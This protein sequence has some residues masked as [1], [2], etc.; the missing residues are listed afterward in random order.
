MPVFM[1]SEQN[2]FPPP[3]LAEETGL[4]AVGGDLSRDRLLAAYKNGIFPW[5]SDDEP[6]LW[7]SPDPRLVL[8][9]HELKVHRRLTRTMKTGDFIITFDTAFHE[10]M[11]G[12]AAPR[13]SKKAGTWIVPAMIGAYEHL[14]EAG[15]AHS[16]EAWREGELV[17]GL[18]GV[19][20]GGC[21]F[22]E[23]MFTRVRDASKVAFVTLVQYLSAHHFEMIDCQVITS[24]LVSFGAR[25]IS[26][27]QFLKQLQA[28]LKR[29]SMTG[30]WRDL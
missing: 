27:R 10:V 30:P 8:Y 5:Y 6:I 25:E 29:P 11:L 19:S 4:L 18:Y 7:W 28:A 24:H 13:R 9:P 22:G 12:C 17:G 15:Y 2:I 20:L 14:H 26:R 1:L 16:V 3:H 21:F 23:S